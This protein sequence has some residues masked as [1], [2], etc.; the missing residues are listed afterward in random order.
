MDK[1]DPGYMEDVLP[2]DRTIKEDKIRSLPVPE[3]IL[4]PE[5]TLE[6]GESSLRVLATFWGRW[7]TS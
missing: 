3:G 1:T 2:K 7:A 4:W 6:A 5:I